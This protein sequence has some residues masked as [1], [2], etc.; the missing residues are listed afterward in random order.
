MR[1]GLL[2]HQIPSGKFTRL[3]GGLSRESPLEVLKFF[4]VKE[5]KAGNS[6]CTP[7]RGDKLEKKEKIAKLKF[8]LKTPAGISDMEKMKAPRTMTGEKLKREFIK[9]SRRINSA[10]STINS[11]TR[12]DVSKFKAIIG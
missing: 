10:P 9:S 1:E 4:H 8:Q 11:F 5:N 7:P 3:R 12:F 2:S 6:K